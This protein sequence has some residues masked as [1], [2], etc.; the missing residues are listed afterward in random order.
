MADWRKSEHYLLLLLPTHTFTYT[1]LVQ[2]KLVWQW[3]GVVGKGI[4]RERERREGK[5]EIGAPFAMVVR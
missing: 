3:V 4:Q 1:P 2:A 5:E